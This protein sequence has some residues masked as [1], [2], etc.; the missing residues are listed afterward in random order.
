MVL[1]LKSNVKNLQV[2]RNITYRTMNFSFLENGVWGPGARRSAGEP[3]LHRKFH[4]NLR[5]CP[6]SFN[7]RIFSP[8]LRP[9]LLYFLCSLTPHLA[10]PLAPYHDLAPYCSAPSTVRCR[11]PYS[12]CCLCPLLRPLLCPLFPK[13]A[14]PLSPYLGVRLDLPLHYSLFCTLPSP[15]LLTLMCA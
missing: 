13:L 4:Q 6:F 12:A 3:I 2:F 11:A 10:V 7:R 5:H 1:Y 15:L 9:V 8:L 14:V